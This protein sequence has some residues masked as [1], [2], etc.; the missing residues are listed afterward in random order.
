MTKRDAETFVDLSGKLQAL[1]S[2]VSRA[3]LWPRKEERVLVGGTEGGKG[4]DSHKR[5]KAGWPRDSLGADLASLGTI[6][7]EVQVSF[8]FVCGIQARALHEHWG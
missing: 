4:R 6:V 3:L 1:S 7:V 8:A 5:G 2:C